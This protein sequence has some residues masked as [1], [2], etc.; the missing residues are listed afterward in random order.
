LA[1]HVFRH[2]VNWVVGHID[3]FLF[4]KFVQLLLGQLFR[5]LISVDLVLGLDHSFEMLSFIVSDV[6]EDV[7]KISDFWSS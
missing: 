5:V 2:T 3:S 4:S 1:A 6:E 7:I